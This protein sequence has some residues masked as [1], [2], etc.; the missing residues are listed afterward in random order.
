MT[1]EQD[2][3]FYAT[4][5]AARLRRSSPSEQDLTVVEAL[6]QEL[7]A[8]GRLLPSGGLTQ[9]EYGIQDTKMT[10]R[11]YPMLIGKDEWSKKN[12]T[13]TRQRTVWIG[14]G[15]NG[16]W[17]QYLTAWECVVKDEQD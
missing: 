11:D 9:I 13:H 2:A 5:V 14:D 10:R 8:D 4:R 17:G 7:V 15:P 1:I 3:E 6:L 12:A 16:Q